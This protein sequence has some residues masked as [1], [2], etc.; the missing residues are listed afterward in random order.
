MKH[1]LWIGLLALWAGGA[2]A[3]DA[4]P[5]RPLT[6]I[7]P[8]TPGGGTDIMARLIAEKLTRSLGQPVAVENKPG[9]GG[10]LGTDIAARAAPDGYTLMLGSISTIS[11]NPSLYTNL[12]TNPLTDLA[13]VSLIGS[14]PSILAVPKT[15]PVSS[16]QELIA[17]AKQKPGSVNFGSAGAGTSHH[18]AGELFKMQAN[19]QATHV[20]Y[21]GSA[22]ALLGLTRGDVHILIANIP[23]LL[24]AIQAQQIKP[25]AVTS[26]ERSSLFPEL[27][28]VSES[29]L[30]GFEVIVWYGVFAPRGTPEPIVTRLNAEIRK[31]I[32]MPDVKKR[33]ATEGAEPLSAS[34]QAFAQRIKSD[35]EKWKKVIQAADVKLE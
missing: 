23:S 21:K 20:P 2:L 26:L 12:A 30:P 16:V 27:P 13:P 35:Y 1:K 6:L 11:L 4:Y 34:P 18:L 25:L 17:L 19:I 10:T 14:T 29:G 33:L 7:V 22:P 28:T 8:F 5:S 31:A 24:G 9:A 3:A 32:E 15:L